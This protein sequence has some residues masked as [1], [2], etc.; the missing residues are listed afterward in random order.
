MTTKLNFNWAHFHFKHKKVKI[1][2][3]LTG[4]MQNDEYEELPQHK[5]K[6]LR[7]GP[8]SHSMSLSELV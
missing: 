1:I 7:S 3:F 8:C 4:F 5:P 2:H 6:K